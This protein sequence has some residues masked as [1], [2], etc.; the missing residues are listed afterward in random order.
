MS[1]LK[2]YLELRQQILSDPAL[3]SLIKEYD[4]DVEKL[5]TLLLDQ[6]YDAAEAIR[7]TND[8]EYL[9]GLIEKDPL[10]RK[11]LSAKEAVSSLM[12]ERAGHMCGCKCAVC[13]SKQSC[14]RP[15]K[16][17]E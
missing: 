5:N 13:K 14:R 1:E 2:E 17:N 9:S 10:Y 15:Y 16:E 8:V 6:D 12:Q 7:L 4:S 3:F 11:Y